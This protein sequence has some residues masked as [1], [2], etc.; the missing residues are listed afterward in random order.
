VFEEQTVADVDYYYVSI[1]NRWGW[2]EASS[3]TTVLSETEIDADISIVNGSA[4]I[5]EK[6]ERDQLNEQEN[7]NIE[8]TVYP[9]VLKVETSEGSII[10]FMIIT[11]KKDG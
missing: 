2:V 4:L 10:K 7:F 3:F 8:D 6:P 9:T 1:E 11:K 5:Y